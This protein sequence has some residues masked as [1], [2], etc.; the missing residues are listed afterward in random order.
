MSANESLLAAVETYVAESTKFEEVRRVF[1]NNY[2]LLHNKWNACPINKT[3]MA[4]ILENWQSM[5]NLINTKVQQK[6]QRGLSKKSNQHH[7]GRGEID[8]NSKD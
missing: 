7:K 3:E 1:K 2:W 4:A 6:L 5:S 8:S